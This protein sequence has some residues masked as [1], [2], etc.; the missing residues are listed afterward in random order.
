V[1]A[2][3]GRVAAPGRSARRPARSTSSGL[4]GGRCKINGVLI[5]SLGHWLTAHPE[6]ADWGVAVGTLALALATV[7]L[8]AQ[9]RSEAK[10]VAEQTTI[11]AEQVRVSRAALAAQV[12]PV[13]VDVAA[14]FYHP[15]ESELVP[16]EPNRSDGYENVAAHLVHV[17]AL[18]N[19][20]FVCSVPLRNAGTGLAFITDDP[21]L[22]HPG[23]DGDFIG[24]LTK[25][26]VPPGEQTRAYFG[27]GIP[28][29]TPGNATLIVKV[30]Y[31]DASQ[32]ADPGQS[33]IVWTEA[34][35]SKRGDGWRVIRVAIRRDGEDEPF[36]VSAAAV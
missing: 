14:G 3:P 18:A 23:R 11:S 34:F 16:Y 10:K 35:V 36:V 22:T 28:I 1:S 24:R 13:L 17:G 2:G 25:Q 33:T 29:D 9:A 6:Y 15:G 7:V 20:N 30:P 12:Q 8:A 31:T 27:P 21:R 4:A 32:S 26:A 5:A 19:G